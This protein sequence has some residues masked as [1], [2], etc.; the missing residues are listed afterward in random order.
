MS[1]AKLLGRLRQQAARERQVIGAPRSPDARRTEAPV[2]VKR[3]TKQLDALIKNLASINTIRAI[4]IHGLSAENEMK[5]QMLLKRGR[6]FTIA[7]RELELQITRFLKALFAQGVTATVGQIDE[8]ISE[9][10]EKMIALRLRNGG[11]DVKGS[12]TPLTPEYAAWKRKHFPG[13]PGI[14]YATGELAREFA[15]RAIAI[16]LRR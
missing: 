1:A 11:G 2:S 7:N 4:E 6:D 16:V 9:A 8:A 14:G 15:S 3:D 10:V 12:F 5:F 13:S